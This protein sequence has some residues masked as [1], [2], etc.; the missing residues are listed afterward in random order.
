MFAAAQAAQKCARLELLAP[1]QFAAAQAAQKASSTATKSFVG[2]RC[3]TGSSENAKTPCRYTAA[4]RCRTGSS[5]NRRSGVFRPARVRCRTGSSEMTMTLMQ[6]QLRQ[7]RKQRTSAHAGSQ[8]SLPYRQLRKYS[9][10]LRGQ[11]WVFAAEQAVKSQGGEQRR[12]SPR[13]FAYVAGF[14][15]RGSYDW[16]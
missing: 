4:V 11:L 15:I 7:L 5:E 10:M 1:A 13:V 6:P 2:V 3:R 9:M 14:K 8:C 16:T 12:K